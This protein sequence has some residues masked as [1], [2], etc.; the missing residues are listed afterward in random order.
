M[1]LLVY[2]VHY[3]AEYLTAT[4]FDLLLDRFSAGELYYVLSNNYDSTVAL[5]SDNSG[6]DYQTERRGID[7]HIVV[8]CLSVGHQIGEFL[9]IQQFAGVRRILTGKDYVQIFDLSVEYHVAQINMSC[10]QLTES[11]QVRLVCILG[12]EYALSEVCIDE[13]DFFIDFSETLCKLQR[14]SALSFVCFA[15]GYA[16]RFYITSAKA[17]IRSQCFIRFSGEITVVSE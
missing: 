5:L 17:D 16:D 2:F 14:N 13:Q 11:V 8:V 9:G 12:Q 6:I 4:L 10:E 1:L 7:D 3:S 15:A